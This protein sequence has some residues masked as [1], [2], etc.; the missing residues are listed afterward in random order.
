[1]PPRRSKKEKPFLTLEQIKQLLECPSHSPEIR[2]LLYFLVDTGAR[3]GE[4][5][6]LKHEYILHDED[7]GE[8][9]VKLVGKTGERIVPLSS[10][11]RDLL[12]VLP[13]PRPFPRSSATLSRHVKKAFT[14][15][16]LKGRAHLL[17]HSFVTLWEGN[18]DSLRVITGHS[19]ITMIEA[20]RHNKIGHASREHKLYSPISKLYPVESQVIEPQV[21]SKAIVPVNNTQK[22]MEMAVRVS[23]MR[24]K[25]NWTDPII[26][27]DVTKVER[28]INFFS[29]VFQAAGLDE[30]E[31]HA[32]AWDFWT[33]F[34]KED[35]DPED[36]ILLKAG[37]CPACKIG[38]W[39]I[40]VDHPLIDYECMNCGEKSFFIGAH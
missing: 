38:G 21:T 34:V 28:F 40:P 32:H 24:E 35:V 33:R 7:T 20:Y 12:Q 31:A 18:L 2:A 6:N 39:L 36:E 37:I 23:E 14:D 8:S 15:A 19:D 5:S 9:L 10:K 26:I 27:A 22:L 4:A 3:I 29:Y 1:M 13:G 11:V 17:R 25:I 30:V 16:G